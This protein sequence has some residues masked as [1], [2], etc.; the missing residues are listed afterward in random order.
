M[1]RYFFDVY[2]GTDLRD[3]VGRELEDDDAIIRAEALHVIAKLMKAE[4]EDAKETALILTVRDETGAKP[5]TVRLVC[6]VEA[7]RPQ[8][9]PVR[10]EPFRSKDEDESRQ[11]R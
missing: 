3:E 4:A 11:A 7:L 5:L 8:P 1:P 9:S 6:Q 2:D 10:G